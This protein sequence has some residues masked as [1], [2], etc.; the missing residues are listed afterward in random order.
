MISV[1]K[2]TPFYFITT[3]TH[4]RLPIFRTDVLKKVMCEALD[5]ARESAGFLIFG[6]A[7]MPDHYHIVT[8]SKLTQSETLR[9]L[10]GVSANR[11]VKYLKENGHEES[12]K[13]LRTAEKD[14]GYKHSVWE[15]HSNTFE[16]KTEPVLMQKINYIH[17]NPVEDGLAETPAGYLYSSAR[18]WKGCPLENEPLRMDVQKIKWRQS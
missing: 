7:I 3:V 8:D 16:I 2:N 15:H 4:D 17:F 10:N 12:L 13:K 5:A 11:I 18:I 1:S 9:Y 6:Y 14:R